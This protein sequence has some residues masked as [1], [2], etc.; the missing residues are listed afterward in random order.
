MFGFNP[1]TFS[2]PF[3]VN[4]V[5]GANNR[6]RAKLKSQAFLTDSQLGGAATGIF[7][8]NKAEDIMAKANA[9]A[10]R[11]QQNASTF[12][13]IMGAVGSIGSFG[14]AGVF[15]PNKT[16]MDGGIFG[17]TPIGAGGGTLPKFGLFGKETVGTLGPNY[18][19]P[20]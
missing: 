16:F 17:K 5:A 18:G 7:A 2:D 12:G 11:S 14:A 13:N 15:D 19:I 4:S 3:D 6:E 10:Q 20:Q 1:S 9:S 8:R